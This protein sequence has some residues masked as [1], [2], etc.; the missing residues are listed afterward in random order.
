MIHPHRGR[1]LDPDRDV[2]V[3]R[4]LLR[5]GVWYSVMQR[6]L[7]V[8]HVDLVLLADVRFVVRDGGCH[9]AAAEGRRNVHA[10]AVGRWREVDP[11]WRRPVNA[12]HAV[13]HRLEGRFVC[14]GQPITRAELAW[15]GPSGLW[16]VSPS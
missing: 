11:A 14:D 9:R 10:F 2:W 7:V 12:Q 15:L 6:S 1:S 16:V 4:N 13:Y 5:A 8:A 3:Y